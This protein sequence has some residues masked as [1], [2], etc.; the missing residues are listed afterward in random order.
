MN[1]RFC[2][3]VDDNIRFLQELTDH[4]TESIFQHPYLAMYKR[5]H[6]KY[7]L[8]IQLNLFY[9]T[10]HFNLSQMTDRYREEWQSN[11]DWL[12]LSFHSR[13]ENIA[14]Y[15][16]SG[17]D[18]V[19]TDC[20]NVHRE[21]R[22]FAS[23]EAMGKTTTVHYCLATNE[24]IRAL[25]DHGVRGL[26]GLYGTPE[27]PGHSY[28]TTAADDDQ[29]RRGEVVTC[30][31]IAYAGIDIVLNQWDTQSICAR[32]KALWG[33]PL[34]KVMIHEQYFYPDY[35]AYQ[36]DFEQKLDSTFGD[37]VNQGY[38]SVFFESCI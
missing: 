6:E 5:L 25:K 1:K 9:E 24:G 19:Y 4:P 21:I 30:D 29:I 14:P 20:Q 22:R 17:Y 10:E 26:L 37:L 18:E 13:V 23:A 36:P 32:L 34:I 16:Y 28:Q 35:R 38:H 12:K 11:A 7:G 8:K 33:R 27:K 15:E 31:G 3:T 2:F